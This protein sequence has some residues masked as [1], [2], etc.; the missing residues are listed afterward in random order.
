MAATQPLRLPRTQAGPERQR[1][2]ATLLG[3]YWFW[4]REHLP[5]AVLVRLLAEFGAS[6]GSARAAIRR[7]AERGVLV[8]SRTGRTTSYG[9]PFRTQ[10]A[11][12][13]HAQRLLSF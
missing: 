5:S 4:R 8:G 1:L 6:A 10:E 3:D 2:L 12:I 7:L 13:D 11:L 9:L